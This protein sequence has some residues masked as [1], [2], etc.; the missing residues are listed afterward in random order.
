ML[1]RPD[2]ESQQHSC[3]WLLLVSLPVKYSDTILTALVDTWAPK[4]NRQKKIKHKGTDDAVKADVS[5]IKRLL[6]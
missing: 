5:K 3:D 4:E 1:D 2:E 6:S